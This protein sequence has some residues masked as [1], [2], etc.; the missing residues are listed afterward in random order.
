MFAGKAWELL[1][2]N[3]A[4]A[5]GESEDLQARGQMLL[6]AHLAGL[7]V[8][9]SMLGA[10]HG[11]ANPLTARFGITHGV[12]VGL[13]LPHVIRFNS[14]SAEGRYDELVSGRSGQQ[15]GSSEVLA[16]EVEAMKSVGEMTYNLR[17]FNVPAEALETLAAEAVQEWTCGFN[18]RPVDQETIAE[19]Y[20][21]AF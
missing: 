19:L 15:L 7:A 2:L 21:E 20:R 13:M 12:A 16:R 4:T 14:H 8:E 10:A 17:D 11:C 3:Y 5:L 9:S 1:R 18:P 6:G